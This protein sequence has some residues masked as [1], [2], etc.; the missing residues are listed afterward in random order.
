MPT[1]LLT[2]HPPP[3]AEAAAIAI[4][5]AKWGERPLLIVAPKEGQVRVLRA[6]RRWLG[7]RARRGSAAPAASPSRAFEASHSAPVA[8][9]PPRLAPIKE[10]G[11]GTLRRAAPA[12]TTLTRPP[13][14][15]PRQAPTKESVLAYLDGKLARWQV[16]DDVLFVKARPRCEERDPLSLSL[17]E[18][19][20]ERKACR[21]RWAA[22]ARGAQ[23]SRR[24]AA[25]PPCRPALPAPTRRRH[26]C[27]AL[28]LQ[29]IPH[30]ATGKISKLTLRQQFGGHRPAPRSRM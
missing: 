4:P 29:E 9:P 18:R 21:R 1:P 22:S 12:A 17:E 10:P 6:C 19:E 28:L 23:G 24:R 13:A 14:S 3:P 8:H 20:L 30:T 11:L 16:P 27:A 25:P 26:R 5:D 2:H 7:G 15:P